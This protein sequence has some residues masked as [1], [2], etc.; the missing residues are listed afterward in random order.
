MD[1]FFF[2]KD[3]VKKRNKQFKKT[4]RTKRSAGMA[5]VCLPEFKDQTESREIGLPE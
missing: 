4:N 3:Q 1:R 5:D 2:D